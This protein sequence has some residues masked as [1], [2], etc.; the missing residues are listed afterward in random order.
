MMEAENNKEPIAT[1]WV[2]YNGDLIGT[3]ERSK[4][5]LDLGHILKGE[6][7]ELAH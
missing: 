2:R 1:V 4:D 5:S 6:I 3:G 7:T